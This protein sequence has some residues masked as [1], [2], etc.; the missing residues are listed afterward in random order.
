M[1][2]N[3]LINQTTIMGLFGFIGEITT[4]AVKVAI[5]PIAVV[6]DVV[7]VAT[8]IEAENTTKLVESIGDNIEKG[9]DKLT[10]ER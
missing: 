7:D 3:I 9:I 4:A 2:A 1:L 6:K 10:G 5:T 8:G